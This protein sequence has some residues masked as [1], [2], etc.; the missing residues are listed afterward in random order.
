MEDKKEESKSCF[1]HISANE[2]ELE[3]KDGEVDKNIFDH[4][5]NQPITKEAVVF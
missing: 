5:N 4:E 3:S 2:S 1:W